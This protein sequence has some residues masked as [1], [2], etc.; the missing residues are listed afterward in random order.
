MTCHV[1]INRLD[2]RPMCILSCD[3]VDD[4]FLDRSCVI[5][6][7]SQGRRFPGSHAIRSRDIIEA[8]GSH[9]KSCGGSCDKFPW[10]RDLK[11]TGL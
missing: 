1:L 9:D 5:V 8:E 7:G 10:S 3:I 11:I 6:P 2:T 4:Q